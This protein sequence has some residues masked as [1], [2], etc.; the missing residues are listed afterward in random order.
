MTKRY[1]GV[2]I[3]AVVIIVAVATA[4]LWQGRASAQQRVSLNDMSQND[5]Q[6]V[7]P[8]QNYANLRH[9]TLAQITTDNAKDL[10]V[11]WQMSTGATRGHEGQPLVIGDTMYFE[12]AYPNHVFAVDLN[13]YH[14]KWEFTP[15]QDAFATSVACCDLVNRGVAYGDGMIIEDALDGSVYALNAQTGHVVWKDKTADPELGQTLTSA[16]LVIEG[17]NRVITGV[18]GGEYGVRGYVTAYNLRT[19]KEVWR[20]Y[21]EGPDSQT[22]IGAD[23]HGPRN[24]G[25][26]TWHGDQW[27]V[28]GGTTWGWY[29]YDPKL[30][31]LY[32]GTG[33]PGT[34][35]PSQR[36]GDNKW[37][38]TV[39]ARHPE[40]GQAVWAYQMTPHDQ[41]DYDGINEMILA[42]IKV[43]GAEVPALVHFDRNGFAF[44]LNRRTG[45]LLL[46]HKFDPDV[47]WAT[48][49][50][51]TTERPILDPRYGTRAGHNTKGICP[52][53]IG[54][55]N[56]VP[57]SYD[58]QSG[59]FIVPTNHW[60]EDYQPFAVKYKAGF[61]FVGAIVKMY[62]GPG[63][64]GGA[65]IAWDP[66]TGKIVWSDHEHFPVWSG[67]VTTDGGVAFYGTMDGWF[68]AVDAKTGA[69]LFKQKL[70][71]GI[72]GNPIVYSH[73]G[74]EFV[75][76]FSGVGGWAGIGLA[77][78]LTNPTAGL[79]AVGAGADLGKYTTLGGDLTVFSL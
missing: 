31:L 75:A 25:T 43:N 62:K 13:D 49:Y 78:G 44:E 76:T 40:N 37:A 38:M 17:K 15:T 60:C 52:A 14:I 72:I 63:G 65:L 79:G 74:K 41:W 42:N 10:K 77:A 6:W 5:G 29:S 33:N 28:G 57:A 35:N 9:S 64:Y 68:K 69:L 71:S 16:P 53:S 66:N 67:V 58:P 56:N 1:F 73:G 59:Y 7:M 55:K 26:N 8:S 54:A 39:F 45:K 32:Y 46:A 34:W 48:G 30:D 23:F 51:M 50:N 70:P 21:S 22:L 2:A 19:G 61:P 11:A 12:S 27:K 47:N 20:A 3:A 4:A 24:A 36:P 18:S